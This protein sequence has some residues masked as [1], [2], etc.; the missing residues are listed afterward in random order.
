MRSWTEQRQ[1]DTRIGTLSNTA[2]GFPTSRDEDWRYTDLG[3]LAS[4]PLKPELSIA[5]PGMEPGTAPPFDCHLLDF[6]NGRFNPTDSQLD[7]LPDGVT[8]GSLADQLSRHPERIRAILAGG[9]E[10]SA[11]ALYDLN[12]SFMADGAWIELE[13]GIELKRPILL[14]HRFQS[15]A[16][17]SDTPPAHFPHNLIT[18]ADGSSATLIEYW[19]QPDDQTCFIDGVTRIDCGSGARLQ[20]IQAQHGGNKTSHVAEHHI[21][22]AAGSHYQS[23]C[24]SAG[25]RLARTSIH[26]KLDGENSECRLAGLHIGHDCAHGDFHTRIDH[27]QPGCRSREHYRAI[28]GDRSRGAFSGRA[29]V[30]PGARA[31]DVRQLHRS[32]LLSAHAEADSRPQLEIHADEVQCSHGATVGAL[33]TEA[34]FYLISRGLDTETAY[35]LLTLAFANEVLAEIRDQPLRDWLRQMI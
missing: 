5:E 20:H 10:L 16:G 3:Q 18:L 1:R 28:L 15:P 31:S 12:R 4:L 2:L 9:S 25:P 17:R 24:L 21:H 34:L 14:R 22:Q 32:L 8:A 27:Q 19:Q 33:D 26:V 35:Q 23:F 11:S 30:H 13:P 7:A 29:V 6:I